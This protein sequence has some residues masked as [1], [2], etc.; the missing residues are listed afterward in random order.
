LELSHSEVHL[1]IDS[2]AMLI[3]KQFALF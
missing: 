2:Y 3:Y 1:S